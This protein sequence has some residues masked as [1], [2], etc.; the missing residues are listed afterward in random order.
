M[1]VQ[2][3]VKGKIAVELSACNPQFL[4]QLTVLSILRMTVGVFTRLALFA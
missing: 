1:C 4:I 3:A 2:L